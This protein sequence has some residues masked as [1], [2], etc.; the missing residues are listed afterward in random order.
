MTWWSSRAPPD[1]W[2]SLGPLLLCTPASSLSPRDT[3]PY[4]PTPTDTHENRWLSPGRPVLSPFA[5]TSHS[6]IHVLTHILRENHKQPSQ[7]DSP[8]RAHTT[9][10]IQSPAKMDQRAAGSGSEKPRE[11]GMGV[12]LAW[13]SRGLSADTSL[14]SPGASGRGQG[15]LCPPHAR[16]SLEPGCR[17]RRP[18]QMV[19]HQAEGGEQ[20]GEGDAESFL[21]ARP[22]PCWA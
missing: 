5:T 16:P 6:H 11:L 17:S 21:W 8:S 14:L 22:G 2:R 19:P 3:H 4:T 20:R 10:G 9:R 15:P 18:F 7:S 1:L 13:N 12:W